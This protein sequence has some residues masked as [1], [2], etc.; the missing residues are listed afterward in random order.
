MAEEK[1]NLEYELRNIEDLGRDL[2]AENVVQDEESHLETGLGVD[3]NTGWGDV[4]SRDWTEYSRKLVD[5][6]RIMEPDIQKRE[7]AR[8]QL[9]NIHDSSKW[10]KARIKAGEA[11]GYS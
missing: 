2:S 4:Y 11:L 5:K 3:Y 10:Y 7:L 6:P 8:Q 1:G 9:Q